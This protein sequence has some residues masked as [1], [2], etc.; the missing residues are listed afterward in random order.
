M[1]MRQLMRLLQLILVLPIL[2]GSACTAQNTGDTDGGENEEWVTFIEGQWALATASEEYVC[3]YKTLEETVYLAGTRPIAPLGTH[4]TFVSVGDARQPDGVVPCTANTSYETFVAGTGLGSEAFEYPDGVGL[5]LEAGQQLLLNLHLFNARDTPLDGS[6]GMEVK[7][8][9][10]DQVEHEAGAIVSANTNFTIPVG[11]GE[12]T[13]ACTIR[14]DTKVFGVFPHMH[15]LGVHVQAELQTS[16]GKQMILDTD[17]L[18]DAQGSYP[19]DLAMKAGDQVTTTCSYS[20]TTGGPVGYGD[21]T[22]Q[23]MCVMAM[24]SY[25][26]MQGSFFCDE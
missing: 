11:A 18:F 20:N 23:E 15:Q 4:H 26:P 1:Q 16:V 13:T 8:L 19:A 10:P 25:P 22:L 3:V 24:F 14:S 21:S 17:Y 9:T 5:R 7:T 2:L 6:S 12:V